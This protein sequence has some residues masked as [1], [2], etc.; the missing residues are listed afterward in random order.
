MQPINTPTDHIK[1]QPTNTTTRT[2]P[3]GMSQSQTI[4]AGVSQSRS[5]SGQWMTS[6]ATTYISSKTLAKRRRAAER[7]KTAGKDPSDPVNWVLSESDEESDSSDSEEEKPLWHGA[8]LSVAEL[9]R[10]VSGLQPNPGW[11]E[12]LELNARQEV[13]EAVRDAPHNGYLPYERARH[14]MIQ[15]YLRKWIDAKEPNTYEIRVEEG[16]GLVDF[17]NQ[18]KERMKILHEATRVTNQLSAEITQL[19]RE[20][21]T[22]RMKRGAVEDPEGFAE[23]QRIRRETREELGLSY[24]EHPDLPY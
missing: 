14:D 24:E 9:F 3:A 16:L 15:I 13:L 10:S 4:P 22:A 17:F 1:T 7:A 5:M 11:T 23:V 2:I 18:C 21:S 20:I 8:H 19:D 12:D 6:S